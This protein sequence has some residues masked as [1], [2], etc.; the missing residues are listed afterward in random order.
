M[1]IFSVLLLSVLLSGL[2]PAGEPFPGDWKAEGGGGGET[3]RMENGNAVIEAAFPGGVLLYKERLRFLFAPDRTAFSAKDLSIEVRA[4]GITAPLKAWIF[5]KDKDGAWFQSGEEFSLK[6]G[7]WTRL[8][9]RLDLSG[10]ELYP[11]GHHA[12]WSGFFASRI[13]AAGLSLYSDRKEKAVIT[14]R[15]PVLENA[16]TDG[17]VRPP[18]A[19]GMTIGSPPSITATQLLV[20]PRSIPMIYAMLRSFNPSG[21]DAAGR[22]VLIHSW[23]PPRGRGE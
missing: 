16:T 18:S 15:S 17:V 9:V 22:G 12:A 2:L 3:L 1:K 13:F 23:P 20:V 11:M 5:L 7:K 4:D 6:P 8:S 21:P 10:H 19:L 14:M